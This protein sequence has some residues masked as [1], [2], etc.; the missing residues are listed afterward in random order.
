MRIIEKDAKTE[1]EM[2]IY[3]KARSARR[4]RRRTIAK[5]MKSYNSLER[6][7]FRHFV[8]KLRNRK[9]KN[10]KEARRRDGESS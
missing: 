6:Q 2:R 8:E 1:E 7:A 9:H 3:K 5:T 10:R 4:K